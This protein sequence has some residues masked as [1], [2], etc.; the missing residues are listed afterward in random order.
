[1]IGKAHRIKIVLL[2]ERSE[3]KRSLPLERKGLVRDGTQT[4]RLTQIELNRLGNTSL[5]TLLEK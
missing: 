1:M 2:S 4:I 3:R 5:A